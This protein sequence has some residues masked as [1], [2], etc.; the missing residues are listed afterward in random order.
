MLFGENEESG[1]VVIIAGAKVV[2]FSEGEVLFSEGEGKGVERFV[3]FLVVL[4]DNVD[5]ADILVAAKSV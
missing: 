5:K 4:G 1:L 2:P 3:I